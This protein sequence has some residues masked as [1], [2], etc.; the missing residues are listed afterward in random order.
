MYFYYTNYILKLLN[1][2]RKNDMKKLVFSLL[3]LLSLPAAYSMEQ[4]QNIHDAAKTGDLELVQELV[5][6]GIDVNKK[7]SGMGITPVQLAA[8]AGHLETVKYLVDNSADINYTVTR[9]WS[10]LHCAV[11]QGR[12]E[13]V[14]YLIDN[15]AHVNAQ[16]V[17]GRTALDYAV[18]KHYQEVFRLLIDNSNGTI[19]YIQDG[20]MKEILSAYY[21]LK[22]TSKIRPTREL[23]KKAIEYGYYNIVKGILETPTLYPTKEDITF[24]K[25]QSIRSYNP[26]IYKKIG[27]LLI[28]YYGPWNCLLKQIGTSQEIDQLPIELSEL[29][30]DLG[31]QK[32]AEEGSLE[33]N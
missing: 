22:A 11:S 4:N 5:E 9:G 7:R 17:L 12:L 29:I 2:I 32:Q 25:T 18:M 13:I 16:D 19:P 26:A 31:S 27:R 6:S 14:N 33:N 21:E 8:E 30:I 24:A 3:V 1:N 23:L 20:Y 15:G 10:T 28:A